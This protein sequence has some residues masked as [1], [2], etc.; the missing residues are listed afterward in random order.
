MFETPLKGLKEGKFLE[1]NG[2][3]VSDCWIYRRHI[4]PIGSGQPSN[5]TGGPYVNCLYDQK[6]YYKGTNAHEAVKEWTQLHK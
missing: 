4:K 6:W 5:T 1:I 3:S 2:L